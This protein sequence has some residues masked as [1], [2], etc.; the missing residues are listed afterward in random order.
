M[1]RWKCDG[2][3]D[4]LDG[5]DES[6]DTC[7]HVHCHYNAFKCA[8]LLCIR[9]SALCD[10]VNDCGNNED[11]SDQVCAALPKCRHDQFQCENDDCISKN[12][13]CDGQY[14][15]IDGSDEMNCQPPVC[16]FGTC[17][18]ICI[19]KKA[20][21][22]N[23]KCTT[24]YYKGGAKNATCLASGPDQILLLASEQ[25][26]RFILP[27]KQEGTTVVGFFQTD[28]LKID[29]FDILIRPKDTLL[30][31][32]DSHHGK[33][34]TMKIATPHVEGTGVRV[35]RDLKELTAFNVSELQFLRDLNSI[36][37]LDRYP[38]WM[39]PS[40]WPLIG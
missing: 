26:F 17:S 35:R 3:D 19:E 24:G 34:H 1:S 27:A 9:K 10:G 11:E 16:G 12:F 22:Y 38:I 18:Q 29:V 7:A 8:N 6:Y 30:F 21:H 37:L 5:S 32:I 39:T 36:L 25:E 2:W 13:R 14:N 31:W 23:C 15:C 40:R 4:C 28:S 33:V 20:G